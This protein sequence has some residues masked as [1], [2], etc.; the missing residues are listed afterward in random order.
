M[1]GT[2]THDPE[3]R[4][5]IPSKGVRPGLALPAA[6]TRLSTVV[7]HKGLLHPAADSHLVLVLLASL[8]RM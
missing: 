5:C 8:G 6:E 3:E 1:I 2:W 4:F 7:P